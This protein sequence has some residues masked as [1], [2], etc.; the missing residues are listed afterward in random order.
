MQLL[1]AVVSSGSVT[2]AAANLGYTPSAVSQ[3]LAALE[4]EAGVSLLE[5]A[6]RGVRPTQ[7]GLLVAEQAESI[8]KVLAETSSQL[9]AL[10]DGCEGRLRIRWA[11]S[12]GAAL[13]PPAVA[14]Y[15]EEAPGIRIEPCLSR[16][17][18]QEL[19]N[20]EADLA[21]LPLSPNTP[22]PTGVRLFHLLDDPFRAVLPANHPLAEHETLDLSQLA[23]ERWVEIGA[24]ALTDPY[25]AVLREACAA[26][27]FLPHIAVRADDF[28]TAQGFVAAGIGV[29]LASDLALRVGGHS[30][31]AV[32]PV[33]KP[34]P[35]MQLYVATRD[36]LVKQKPV[37]RM[38]DKLHASA[39]D[40]IQ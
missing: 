34:E 9:T 7:A 33:Q 31:T 32:R 36:S 21:L 28:L 3:Q 12:A 19:L 26:T 6:G 18:V 22:S 25:Q 23:E 14:R 37:S 40:L 24:T 2:E 17:P 10:R 5:R 30:D 29:R 4:R 35:V 13:I 15:R 27:G 38:L 11:A 1:R 16:A 39:H 20:G 8:A